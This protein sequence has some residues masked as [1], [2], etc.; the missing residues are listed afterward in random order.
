MTIPHV[1]N[2]KDK[3]QVYHIQPKNSS[4]SAKP[5]QQP[6]C[7]TEMIPQDYSFY[8]PALNSTF[9]PVYALVCLKPFGEHKGKH[10]EFIQQGH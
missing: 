6:P 10:R 8:L 7:G 2:I 1:R 9:F 5:R 3:V 4:V